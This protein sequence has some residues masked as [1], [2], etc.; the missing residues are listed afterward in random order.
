M[1]VIGKVKEAMK[2]WKDEEKKD[3]ECPVENGVYRCPICGHERDFEVE[4]RTTV[5][6][7]IDGNCECLEYGDA[8]ELEWEDTTPLICRGCRYGAPAAD[9]EAAYKDRGPKRYSHAFDIG[10]EVETDHVAEDVTVEEL[11]SG[12]EKRLKHLKWL[13]AN[14]DSEIEEACN[15]FDTI[16]LESRED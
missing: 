16:D 12:L 3:E 5:E 10:F 8:K 6:C 7:T 9:F 1:G 4:A 15:A 14:G 2:K 11:V 13:L